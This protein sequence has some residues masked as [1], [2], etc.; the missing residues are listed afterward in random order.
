MK[1]LLTLI[2]LFSLGVILPWGCAATSPD[3]SLTG[4]SGQ[5]VLNIY[6]W[7]SY[8]A[9]QAIAQFEQE[10]NV[11]I[12]YDT[13]D[14][15]ESMYAKLQAGNP[16]YDVVFSPD[17]MVGIMINQG[18]LQPL[19]L[20]M[21]P[22]IIHLDPQFANPPYDPGNQYS[23]PYQWVTLGIGYNIDRVGENINSWSQLFDP[24]FA[25]KVSLLDDMRHTMGAV[26]IY[27][28]Y[29]PNTTNQNEIFAAKDFLIQNS[30]HITAFVPDTGQ[31]LLNQGEVDMT[32]EYSGDIF[33]VMQENPKL[34][35][36]IPQEGTIIGMDN[37]VIPTGAPNPDLALTFINFIMEPEISAQIS[38]FINYGSPNKTAIAEKLIK[39][40][41][42]SNPGIYP[43]PE[44]FA[45]LRYLEDVGEATIFYDQ[46]WTE[47]K[48]GVGS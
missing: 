43:P 19:D 47:V 39:P 3:G 34:R 23:I 17:Y 14:S 16:G 35:Y 38:N 24:D 29:D 28:G 31:N 20:A 30:S 44:V 45:K 36:A 46:A 48:L 2:L 8:I 40:E 41:N 26:L 33:Q 6:N 18:M 25:S 27:L 11:K 12:N 32:M 42:L 10:Y 15:G 9:P 13:Y 4:T 22:N 7:S 1:R 37:M 5:N 21:I